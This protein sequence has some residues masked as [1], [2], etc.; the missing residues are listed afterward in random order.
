MWNESRPAEPAEQCPNCRNWYQLGDCGH[1]S[2]IRMP[3]GS[4][5]LYGVCSEC[6]RRHEEVG[7]M[8][9]RQSADDPPNIHGP[10]EAS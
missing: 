3:F 1:S 2:T 4:S 6:A 10:E 8:W 7:K 9:E 5:T